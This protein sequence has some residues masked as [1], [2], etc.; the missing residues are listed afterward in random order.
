MKKTTNKK[1][2]EI[3]K[4]KYQ[5]IQWRKYCFYFIDENTLLKE[6]LEA[7][8]DFLGTGFSDVFFSFLS[9]G[10]FFLLLTNF[11]SVILN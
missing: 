9:G 2:L 3:E 6:D 11:L 10:I 4:L 7:R 8:D 5:I 1:D